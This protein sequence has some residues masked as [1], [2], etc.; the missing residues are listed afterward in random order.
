MSIQAQID[1]KRTKILLYEKNQTRV[2]REINEMKAL[3]RDETERIA[4]Q[5]SNFKK[6]LFLLTDVPPAID[7]KD[8]RR[9]LS[10]KGRRPLTEKEWLLVKKKRI[11]VGKFFILTNRF[12]GPIRL[13]EIRTLRQDILREWML[14]CR[15]M[16]HEIARLEQFHASDLQRQLRM[17]L[18]QKERDFQQREE[19]MA[20]LRIEITSLQS[21]LTHP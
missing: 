7:G 13:F 17:D 12:L 15:D 4:D 6:T 2:S 21:Q 1:E 5:L 16:E 11:T 18:S 20:L 9:R 19:K 3:L 14:A 10:Q 8:D